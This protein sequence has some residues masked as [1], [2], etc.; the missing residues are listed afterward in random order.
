[1]ERREEEAE[2]EKIIIRS[3]EDVTSIDKFFE[4]IPLD[5]IHDILLNL[6]A[7]S[8]ARFRCV[9]KLWSSI[10]RRPEFIRSFVTQSSTRLCLVVC[11]KTRDK[12][13]FIT[14]PQNEHPDTSYSPVDR[15]QID[16]PGYDYS[17]NQPYSESVHGLMCV[18]DCLREVEVW[19][20]AMR[21]CVTLPSPDTAA[22]FECM[23]GCHY[24]MHKSY[25]LGYDPVEG[26]YKVLCIPSRGYPD[27]RDPLVFTLGPQESWRVI[28]H[29]SPR[30]FAPHWPVGHKGI[31]INGHVYYEA[32]LRFK[33][34]DG[35]EVE[36]ITMSFDVRYEKFKI[37][38]KPAEPTIGKYFMLNYEGKLAWVCSD[39]QS[40]IRFWVLEDEEKQEW[41]PRNFLL[42][43]PINPQCYPTWE[44]V[45]L[46]L[47][48]VTPD[49][50]EFIFVD[51]GLNEIYVLYY[52]P[53][54][55]RTRRVEYE[56]IAGN[57]EFWEANDSISY[58]D[59]V[60]NVYPNHRESL[61]S[62]DNVPRYVSVNG[63]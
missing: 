34:S 62:L 8:A 38:R 24:S 15:F 40:S 32:D 60:I 4:L 19:N 5:L 50:G 6:P 3:K 12:R 9:S 41:S 18:A 55:N 23:E 22:G 58:R 56:G 39:S 54:R 61:M 33:V 45:D 16:T 11:V 20:P 63:D 26:K 2:D 51:A 47:E 46:T 42:P 59:T 14:L 10:T 21:Q 13:Y 29:S 1:M 25:F 44:D 30:H 31:C 37:I 28:N 27:P 57:K 52:D 17:Y 35:F 48:G 36:E 53:K 7:K 49:T 43:F